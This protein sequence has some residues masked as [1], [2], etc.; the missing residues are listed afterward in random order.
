MN[1]F[2]EGYCI[3]IINYPSY[4]NTSSNSNT[5]DAVFRINHYSIKEGKLKWAEHTGSGT[6]KNREEALILKSKYDIYWQE[7]SQIN[8]SG[9]G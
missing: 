6:N 5:C 2:K 8:D 3:A 7:Y 4:W 1:N 9:S